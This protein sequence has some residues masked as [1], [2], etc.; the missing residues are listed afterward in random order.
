VRK[1]GSNSVYQG[2]FSQGCHAAFKHVR[3]ELRPVQQGVSQ[4]LVEIRVDPE[5]SIDT[6]SHD[7]HDDEPCVSGDQ[8]EP[9]RFCV[10]SPLRSLNV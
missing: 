9:D 6:E 10:H 4:C 7:H 5:I 8:P 3:N 2:G 1:T